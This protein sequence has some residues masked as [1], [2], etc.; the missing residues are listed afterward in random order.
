MFDLHHPSE[1]ESQNGLTVS[2]GA[3]NFDLT[4]KISE[5]EN[6]RYN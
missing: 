5:A 4:E 2:V 6:L 3:F 1:M